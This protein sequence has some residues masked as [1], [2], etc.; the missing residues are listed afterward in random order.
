MR[1]DAHGLWAAARNGLDRSAGGAG[2]GMWQ[3]AGEEV[4]ASEFAP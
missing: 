2:Q 3:R 1:R 4:L